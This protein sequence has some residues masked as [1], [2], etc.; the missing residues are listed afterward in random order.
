MKISLI[1]PIKNEKKRLEKMLPSLFS[2][3]FTDYEL[4]FVDDP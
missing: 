3:T 4:I 2:Q 1:I